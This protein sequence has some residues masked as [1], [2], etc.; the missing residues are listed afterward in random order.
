M[1]V[2]IIPN[3]PFALFLSANGVFSIAFLPKKKERA[4]FNLPEYK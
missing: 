2:L 3:K 1:F 4:P